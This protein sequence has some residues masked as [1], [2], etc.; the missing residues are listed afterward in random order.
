V[1]NFLPDPPLTPAVRATYDEDLAELGH[2]MNL[3]RL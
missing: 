2:V 1:A 3:T